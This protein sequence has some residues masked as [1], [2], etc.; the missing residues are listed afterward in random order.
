MSQC[1]SLQFDN[2]KEENERDWRRKSSK[3]INRVVIF[4]QFIEMKKEEREKAHER[5]ESTLFN[6]WR[7][8]T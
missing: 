4:C 3:L 8:D 1:R 6:Q 5:D 7:A 2:I